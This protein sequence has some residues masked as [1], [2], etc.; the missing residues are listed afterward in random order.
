MATEQRV[1]QCCFVTLIYSQAGPPEEFRKVSVYLV[2]CLCDSAGVSML[3]SK[4]PPVILI[5]FCSS[6]VCFCDERTDLSHRNGDTI[7][8]KDVSLAG[9]S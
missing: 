4:T 9:Y 3:P 7:H 1:T 5:H 2:R 8:T 6:S